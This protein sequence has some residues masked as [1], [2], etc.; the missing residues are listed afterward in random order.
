MDDLVRTAASRVVTEV[1]EN[2]E[3]VL[4]TDRRDRLKQLMALLVTT[5][6]RRIPL[7]SS[8]VVQR[9]VQQVTALYTT[10]DFSRF[11]R[12]IE[13][14]ITPQPPSESPPSSPQTL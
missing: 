14:I 4:D 12:D 2:S 13:I 1:R 6:S 5:E 11:H 9:L 7:L 10:F 8:I 3:F